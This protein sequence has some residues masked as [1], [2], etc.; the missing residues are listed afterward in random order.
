MFKPGKCAEQN[1]R[2][3]RGLDYLWKVIERVKFN[4]GAEVDNLDQAG[5]VKFPLRPTFN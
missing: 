4:D 1:W 2:K 3:L 5:S